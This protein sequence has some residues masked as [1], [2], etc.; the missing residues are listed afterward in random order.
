VDRSARDEE[1]IEGL[2]AGETAA[3]AAL[4]DR[5]AGVVFA[6]LVRIVADRQVAEELLQEAFLRAWQH[7]GS[8]ERGRGSV[9]SWLLGIAH[10]LALNELRRRRRRPGDAIGGQARFGLDGLAARADP[11][12][13][14]A[15]AAWSAV[16]HEELAR[17]LDRLPSAQRAV[18]ELYAAGYTQAE[19]AV[20]LG[21]PLGTIKSRM[22]RGL[23]QLRDAL[24][25]LGIDLD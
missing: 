24:R 6:L 8:Y 19:I 13:G 21:Q 7:A 18:I 1:L 10:N 22:R 25:P 12:P 2:A 9:R 3:L 4:Y 11:R 5:H 16:R 14:P 17:A 20:R 15:E 23:H